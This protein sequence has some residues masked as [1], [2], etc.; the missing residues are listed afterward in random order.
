MSRAHH[1]D[2]VKKAPTGLGEIG[3]RA[4]QTS[5]SQLAKFRQS[6]L[7]EMI[8]AVGHQFVDRIAASEGRL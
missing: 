5:R 6:G 8:E 2:A 7:I 4:V 3:S 1:D